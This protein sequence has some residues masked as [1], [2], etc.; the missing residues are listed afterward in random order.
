VGVFSSQF[1]FF[2]SRSVCRQ[3]FLGRPI[4]VA[5]PVDVNEDRR[6][7]L[8]AVIAP[9]RA[10]STTMVDEPIP[11]RIAVDDVG[12]I[13]EPVLAA[14]ADIHGEDASG[15]TDRREV[16][17]LLVALSAI[18]G[19][20]TMALE[21]ADA[22]RLVSAARVVLLLVGSGSLLGRALTAPSDLAQPHWVVTSLAPVL[23]TLVAG[24]ALVVGGAVVTRAAF[25]GGTVLTVASL[26]VWLVSIAV[27][28]TEAARRWIRQ[29]LNVPARRVSGDPIQV[30]TKELVV[31]LEPG[32]QV[33]VEAGE[34]VPVDLEIVDGEVEVSRWDRS[35]LR[36]RRG[37][38]DVL[39]AGS[40]ISKGQLRGVC[41]WVGEQRAL[42]RPLL[43]DAYRSDVHSDLARLTRGV[44]EKWAPLAAVVAGV[45]YALIGWAALDVGMVFVAV[46]A[47]IGNVAVG[48]VAALGI[49]RGVRAALSHGVVYNDA[50]AWDACA[51]VTAAVFCA[52]GTLLRGEPE[53]VEAEV[54][55][56][57]RGLSADEMLSLAAG[58][59]A[60]ERHPVAVAVRRAALDRGLSPDPVR[61][62]RSV[63]GGGA[64]AVA[65]TGESLCVGGRN[66]L[67]DRSVSVA[68]AESRIY[69]LE[70]SGRTVV[71]VARAD[72]LIG[73]LA[74]QDGLRSGARAAV[75]HL[76]DAKM[77]P[78][79][80]SADTRETCEALGRA[81]DIDHL[82]PE[83]L[84]DERPAAVQRIK[85]T[86]AVVAVLGHTP[87]DDEALGAADV[88]VA[89]AAAGQ[90]RDDFAVSLVS[91]DV[92]DA[93][94][95]LSLASRSR[96]HAAT[97]FGL[98]F[99]PAAFGALVVAIGILPPEYAP[100]A[101]L[102]GAAVAVWY[103]RSGDRVG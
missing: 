12:D 19:V 87:F 49:A 31:D 50:R 85:D 37:P 22:S 29:K 11:D 65:V 6:A 42:A 35:A 5:P 83:V 13:I 4:E 36:G 21:L 9:V 7:E 38:G 80:M 100:L 54:F 40:Q 78:I 75:Q 25:L 28:P 63:P 47:A 81:L 76:L 94:V 72:R 3:R 18:A 32:E 20:L 48:S 79:L 73:L 97:A 14:G 64:T 17:M 93:A 61:N 26:N 44:A 67:L 8:D 41:T 46:Y 10:A 102:L 59:M 86:G 96:A 68:A 69:Q 95:G 16:G 52:R 15:T 53:L 77:E 1:H 34:T 56:R 51:G 62:P 55:D 88:S 103:L 84:D 27:R 91:D 71:L 66:L 98:V 30:A 70:G 58:V 60:R 39:V 43:A 24:W 23:A 57:R 90:T 92:R 99:A 82:R 33:V 2:C 74:L 45:V 89:L 101:Q